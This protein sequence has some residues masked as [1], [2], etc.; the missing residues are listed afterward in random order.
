MKKIFN[1]KLYTWLNFLLVIP[2]ISKVCSFINLFLLF[3]YN[4]GENKT[5]ENNIQKLKENSK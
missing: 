3:Y 5:A 2:D 1:F 4:T